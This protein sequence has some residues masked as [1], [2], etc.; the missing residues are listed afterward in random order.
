MSESPGRRKR[1][2]IL[3]GIFAICAL[4]LVA[5]AEFRWF[6]TVAPRSSEL[7]VT[8]R[9]ST[10]YLNLS[11][12]ATQ[13]PPENS[14]LGQATADSEVTLNS[15]R[16]PSPIV[17]RTVV[18]ASTAGSGSHKILDYFLLMDLRGNLNPGLPAKFVNMTLNPFGVNSDPMLGDSVFSW[19]G[20]SPTNATPPCYNANLS[21][22]KSTSTSELYDL[23]SLGN[24]SSSLDSIYSFNLPIQILVELDYPTN[25]GG[26][27]ESTF[28]LGGALVGNYP[29]VWA[30]M[31]IEIT[32]E[33]G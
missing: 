21:F 18:D 8:Q 32:A 2:W 12:N 3:I 14:S 30:S 4:L 17:L 10:A 22:N 13:G 1:V 11:W 26:S 28:V 9:D 24:D 6:D 7:D 29:T 25:V 27:P 15:S 16:L 5:A 19:P 33:T 20:E 31:V 23:V